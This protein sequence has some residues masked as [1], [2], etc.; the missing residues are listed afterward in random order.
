MPTDWT[1]WHKSTHS[2]GGNDCVETR[3][4]TRVTGFGGAE[5]SGGFGSGSETFAEVRDTKGPK[6]EVLAFSGLAW[7]SFLAQ[8]V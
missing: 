2:G 8:I 3:E 1:R 7:R 6:D 5:G 4:R